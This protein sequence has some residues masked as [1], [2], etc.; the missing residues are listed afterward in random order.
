[1]LYKCY[2]PLEGKYDDFEAEIT[3]DKLKDSIFQFVIYKIGKDY[4]YPVIRLKF[5][6]KTGEIFSQIGVSHPGC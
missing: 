5:Y 3:S 1:M 2:S 4:K 6:D